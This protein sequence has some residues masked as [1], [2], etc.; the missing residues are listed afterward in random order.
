MDTLWVT[1]DAI[2]YTWTNTGEQSDTIYPIVEEHTTYKVMAESENGCTAEDNIKVKVKMYPDVTISAPKAVCHGEKAVLTANGANEYV[3]QNDPT[4]N[5]KKYVDSPEKGTTY[6]VRGTTKGC[7][8]VASVYVDVNPL[9]YVWITG[10]E[11]I[12]SG[13]DIALRQRSRLLCMEHK[14]SG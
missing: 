14:T 4:Q 8:S 12:C 6:T 10:N 13:D 2:R 5:N 7:T 9:P 1:G 11:S 3:W